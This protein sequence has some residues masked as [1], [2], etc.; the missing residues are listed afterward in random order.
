[1][2]KLRF[3]TPKEES[4]LLKVVKNAPSNS[5]GIKMFAE[6]SNR[7]ISGVNFKFYSLT[8]NSNKPKTK[9]L[10][11]PVGSKTKISVE[12]KLNTS[13]EKGIDLP[14]GFVFNFTPKKAEMFDNHVR[15][16]F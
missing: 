13:T 6:Q 15:L 5:E 11:R 9:K 3:W 4:N 8:G 16:Y 10:G 1:M 12:R 7:T 2:A 14:N